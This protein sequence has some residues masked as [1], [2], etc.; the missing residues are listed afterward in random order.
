MKMEFC[1]VLSHFVEPGYMENKQAGT[2]L[3]LKSKHNAFIF[4]GNWNVDWVNEQHL[5]SHSEIIPITNVITAVYLFEI[6]FRL[7]NQSI[8]LSHRR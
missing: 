6:Y 1:F 2:C 5:I 7:D 8:E 3:L 4:Q